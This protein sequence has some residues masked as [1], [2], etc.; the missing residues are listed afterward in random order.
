[1]NKQ[2]RLD[3]LAAMY[4]GDELADLAK[5]FNEADVASDA[6]AIPAG[7]YRCL[8][9]SGELNKSRSGT[10]GYRVTFVVD[11][12]EHRGVRLRLDCWLTPAALPMAKRDLLK[13]GVTRLDAPFPQG[14]V[15]DVV[16][17]KYSDDD[18][19][20]R[21]KVRSFA[22]VERLD[23]PSVDPAFSRDSATLNGGIAT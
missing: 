23:D 11:D 3:R 19:T 17:V 18:G 6:V 12:G 9:V 10:P 16:V 20:E 21:N 8:A 13:F 1:M 15:A 22:I 4:G 2:A 7:R 5:Q 14:Y